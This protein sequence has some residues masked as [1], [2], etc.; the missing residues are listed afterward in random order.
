MVY[1]PILWNLDNQMIQN[2]KKKKVQLGGIRVTILS[3]YSLSIVIVQ[4]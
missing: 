2:I 1:S 4:Q 3:I